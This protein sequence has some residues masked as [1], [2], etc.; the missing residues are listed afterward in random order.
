LP[1]AAAVRLPATL[2]RNAFF[3]HL[4]ARSFRQYWVVSDP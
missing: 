1:H 2:D 3:T 4:Q